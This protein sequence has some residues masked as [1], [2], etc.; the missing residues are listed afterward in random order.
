MR[1]VAPRLLGTRRQYDVVWYGWG[2][3]IQIGDAVLASIPGV[4]LIHDSRGLPPGADYQAKYNWWEE[5]AQNLGSWV[6]SKYNWWEEEARNLGSW[7]LWNAETEQAESEK[8]PA[9]H[10]HH[11][12]SIPEAVAQVTISECQDI[13]CRETL[14]Q[15]ATRTK[16][17]EVKPLVTVQFGP[18]QNRQDAKAN[19]EIQ[20]TLEPQ[21]DAATALN[22]LLI[23]TQMR[24]AR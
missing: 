7:V 8:A 21:L 20:S 9:Y 17:I 6:L 10:L 18:E 3:F 5:E 23:R 14:P 12:N 2:L 16:E 15:V 22:P 13:A 11:I 1:A 24:N 19:L 4:R